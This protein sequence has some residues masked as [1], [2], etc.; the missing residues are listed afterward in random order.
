MTLY[1]LFES[2]IGYAL[3]QKLEFDEMNASSTQLQK[4]ISKMDSFSKMVRLK[5]LP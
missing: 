1:L 2:A 3:F 4:S 5:V